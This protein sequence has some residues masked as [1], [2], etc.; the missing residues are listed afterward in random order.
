M[1]KKTKYKKRTMAVSPVSS[2]FVVDS[3]IIE[4]VSSQRLNV[5]WLA[6]VTVIS[7]IYKTT[8]ANVDMFW[9]MVPEDLLVI[10]NII[11][12]RHVKFWFDNQWC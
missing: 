5:F 2:V 11:Y 4:S 3:V 10:D 8:F 6:L 1:E 7:K 12:D 9:Y